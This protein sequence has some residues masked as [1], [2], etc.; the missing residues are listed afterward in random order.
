MAI[1]IIIIEL[2][3]TKQV[4]HSAVAHPSLTNAQLV[5]EQQSTTPCQLPPVYTLGMTSHGKEHSSGQLGSAVL[6]VS[7]PN[8]LCPSSLLAGWAQEAEKSLT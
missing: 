2:E 3:Y 5:S 7:P 8:F 1:I 4:M 6:A